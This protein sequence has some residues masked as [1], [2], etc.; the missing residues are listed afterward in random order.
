M[1]RRTPPVFPADFD[2]LNLQTLCSS[3]SYITPNYRS[4]KRNWHEIHGQFSYSLKRR[5]TVCKQTRPSYTSEHIKYRQDRLKRKS[6]ETLELR[7]RRHE[8]SGR[9]K[10]NADRLTLVRSEDNPQQLERTDNSTV[11]KRSI[12]PRKTHHDE[13]ETSQGGHGQPKKQQ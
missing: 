2:V 9:S 13:E 1:S 3:Y 10:N 8:T 11:R 5:T 4:R 12:Q 6:G 7:Q